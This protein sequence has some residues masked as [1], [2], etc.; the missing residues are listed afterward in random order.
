MAT[1][2]IGDIQGCYTPFS[3]LL[4][5]IRFDP[6]QDRLWLAGDLVNRGPHS[7]AVLRL[8]RKLGDA[9]ITVLGN[10]D[11]FL[12]MVAEG[13]AE[14]ARDDTLD[15]VLRAPDR[16]ELLH[17]LA[18]RPMIHVEERHVLVHAGL[19]PQWSV[20]Q[21]AGLGGEIEA[22]LRGPRRRDL[23]KHLYGDKPSRWEDELKGWDRL[24]FIVNAM[25]RMRCCTPEGRLVLAAKGPPSRA[26]AGS[27][28]W[29]RVPNPAW[30]THTVV[31]GHW[32]A[33]GL[34]R[35]PGVLALDTGCVWGGQLTAVRLE[36]GEVFQEEA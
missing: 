18:G 13:V 20:P 14:A 25:T 2:A 3:R 27:L 33:L 19:V 21:A 1:Y 5:R 35:E 34:L 8:V 17:W 28:P 9:A 22:M 26:P 15:D 16:D 12:L 24:R 7:A 30:A 10:H 11:L 31:F 32:S 29:F 23:L 4:E 36:D 6:S